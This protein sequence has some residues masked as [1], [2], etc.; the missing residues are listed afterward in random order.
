VTEDDVTNV[1]L[2]GF[3]FD[4]NHFFE[5]LMLRFLRE[6]LPGYTVID[7]YRL[8]GMMSYVP[9]YN[10]R[11]RQAPTPRPDYV[12]S[13]DGKI[14]AMLDAK[15]R[16]IWTHNLP[17]DMLYQLAIYALSQGTGG[18]ATILYPTVDPTA[19]P[20][21]IDIREVLYGE[22]RAQVVLKPV[23][24]LL[25]EQLLTASGAQAERNCTRYAQALAFGE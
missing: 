7:Q 4:M 23:N 19:K 21:V 3:L 1:P 24:L 18:Q 10:P 13:Q 11:R 12:I 5:V 16:D 2:P 6:N 15:Y 9:G 17:R 14:I 20:E 25:L 8:R 22:H